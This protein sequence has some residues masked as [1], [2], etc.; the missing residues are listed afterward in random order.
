MVVVS[1]HCCPLWRSSLPLLDSVVV[2]KNVAAPHNR[3][4]ARRRVHAAG[5]L[6]DVPAHG[7]GRHGAEGVGGRGR[8]GVDGEAAGGRRHR[9]DEGVV[10]VVGAAEVIAWSSGVGRG[11]GVLGQAAGG[12]A[13]W[14]CGRRRLGVLAGTAA[15]EDGVYDDGEADE[16]ERDA[17]ENAAD[18]DAFVFG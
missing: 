11:S 6:L 17:A 2:A 7:G 4:M 1:V 3:R 15:V 9:A 5:A 10:V 18:D 14:W 12:G 16:Q 13:G 8:G